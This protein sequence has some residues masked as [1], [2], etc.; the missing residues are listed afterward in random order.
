MVAT[1]VTE[2]GIEDEL[3]GVA[4]EVKDRLAAYFADVAGLV[5]SDQ[6]RSSPPVSG[7]E[8]ASP[9]REEQRRRCVD[10]LVRMCASR[11]AAVVVIVDYAEQCRQRAGVSGLAA[12]AS[13]L[14]D[15][16]P[17]RVQPQVAGGWPPGVRFARLVGAFGRRQDPGA[18]GEEPS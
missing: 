13:Q 14:M 8:A 6:T 15:G 5:R 16:L 1:G 18:I 10:A 12:A 4:P 2:I 17:S 9:R 11:N 7:H 3:V